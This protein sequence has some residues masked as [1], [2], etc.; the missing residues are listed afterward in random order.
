LPAGFRAI[1]R[2]TFGARKREAVCGSAVRAGFVV[3]AVEPPVR[4]PPTDFAL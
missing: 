4:M 3:E 2:R 1:I